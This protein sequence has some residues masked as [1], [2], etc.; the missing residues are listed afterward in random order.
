MTTRTAGINTEKGQNA[1][2]PV[3]EH[4]KHSWR[5]HELLPDFEVEDV[6]RF[7]IEMAPEHSLIQFQNEMM[8]GLSHLQEGGAAGAL[9]KLRYFLGNLFGWDDEPVI[10]KAL[11]PGTIRHRYAQEE[12]LTADEMPIPIGAEFTPVYYL[13]N[14]SLLE[15]ENKTVHAALHLGRVPLSNETSTVQLAIY[16]QPKGL[17]GRA[18]MALI[19]PFRYTI[20]YPAM[21]R[22]VKKRWE[23]FLQNNS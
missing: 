7:P 12:G 11:I 15:I 9:F 22:V 13:E 1:Q 8:T 19:K 20:V 21:M 16:V 3:S 5:A 4:M 2:L 18:Y 10:N 23:T 6:W 17:F 14:E